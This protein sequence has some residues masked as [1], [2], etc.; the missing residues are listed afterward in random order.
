[1]TQLDNTEHKRKSV[2]STTHEY[3]SEVLPSCVQTKIKGDIS[4]A[5]TTSAY[6]GNGTSEIIDECDLQEM[7]EALP[8]YKQTLWRVCVFI[9]LVE[10]CE[11]LTYYTIAGS[12]R[13]F[14]ENTGYSN[15][16]STSINS[17]FTLLCYVTP[18]AGGWIADSVLGRYKTIALFASIYLCGTFVTAVAAYPTIMNDGLYLFGTLALI[19]IGTGGIKPNINN[20][21]ADQYDIPGEAREQESFFAYFYWCINIGA[22]VAFGYLVTLATSG[23]EPSIPQ[24][25]GFFAAYC[26]AAGIMV[27]AV[28]FFFAGTTRY[29][30]KPP[31]GDA[32]R[33]LIHYIYNGAFGA[34]T[35][36]LKGLGSAVGW[37]LLFVTL[38]LALAQAFIPG[39]TGKVVGYIALATAF[40]TTFLLTTCHLNNSHLDGC[41]DHK[42]Q[43]FSRVDAQAFLDTVPTIVIGNISFQISYNCMMG[44]M[45]SQAC[46]MDLMVGSSQINGSFFNIG[47]CFSI[48]ICTPIWEKFL[49]PFVERR[50][51]SPVTRNQKLVSGLIITSIAMFIAA[52]LE[53]ARRAAPVLANTSDCSPKNPLTG[54]GMQMSDISAFLIFIPFALIGMGEIMVLPQL[55]YFSY[56]QTPKSGRSV[57]MAFNLLIGGSLSSA[58]TSAFTTAMQGLYPDNLN[59]GHI[60]YF[61]YLGAGF[62][63]CGIPIYLWVSN[64]FV[65]KDFRTEA[66]PVETTIQLELGS[67]E[68]KT[69]TNQL[70]FELGDS[71]KKISTKQSNIC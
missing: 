41:P 43:Y 31:G 7:K 1:M 24:E 69:S 50:K 53:Y 71:E 32:L 15:F 45:M 58:F 18:L 16:Q 55:Y 48:I 23:Q 5:A 67:A 39:T 3:G 63:L 46:Q 68:K 49:Y 60:E 28:L 61:Y 65:A 54:E 12:Q 56:D 59:D 8:W 11:R 20:F 6:T 64:Q 42:S 2:S 36:S 27:F 57:A 70:Q 17:A 25:Y 9:L 35:R 51:G 26:I 14:L 66:D 34:E 52:G 22:A 29:T 38:G 13:N 4:V 62:A 47:D 19:A 33:G 10:M 40:V 21:G 44:V 37:V 30:M